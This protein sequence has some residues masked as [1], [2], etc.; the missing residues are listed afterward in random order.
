MNGYLAR[1]S[2]TL[3]LSA[4]LNVDRTWPYPGLAV[5]VVEEVSAAA[6]PVL[7]KSERNELSAAE[8]ALQVSNSD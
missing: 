7:P 5:F 4:K 2:V 8:P 3:L 6:A 1:Q